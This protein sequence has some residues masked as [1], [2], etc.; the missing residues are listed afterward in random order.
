MIIMYAYKI[1]FQLEPYWTPQAALFFE[2]V[3]NR[4][5]SDLNFGHF[6]L[7]SLY[8]AYSLSLCRA[9]SAVSQLLMGRL[10]AQKAYGPLPT[11]PLTL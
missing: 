9:C 4:L 10:H 6:V 1:K 2:V 11:R 3:A 5:I 7:F 8:R